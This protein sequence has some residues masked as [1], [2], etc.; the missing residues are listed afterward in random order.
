MVKKVAV[1]LFISLHTIIAYSYNWDS[2]ADSI[3]VCQKKVCPSLYHNKVDTYA[4]L[5]KCNYIA[6]KLIPSANEGDTVIFMEHY[7][8]GKDEIKVSFWSK[9]KLDSYINYDKFLNLNN[10]VSLSYFSFYSRWLCNIW[11]VSTIR[12]EENNHPVSKNVYVM[13]TRLI[14]KTDNKIDIDCLFFRCF[15]YH[16]RDNDYIGPFI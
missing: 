6:Q 9:G 10:D 1:A 15:Y 2:I 4:K 12:E 7:Y 5:R 8:Q 14:F 16:P 13:A 3:T 11:D